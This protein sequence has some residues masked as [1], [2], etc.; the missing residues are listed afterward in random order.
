MIIAARLS[1]PFR[2]QS[3]SRNHLTQGVAIG[4]NYKRLSAILVRGK[5]QA[6]PKIEKVLLIHY[7]IILIEL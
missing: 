7:S 4:L 3:N 1:C 6:F 5:I 2:A